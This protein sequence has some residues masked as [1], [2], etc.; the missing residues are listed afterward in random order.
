[1]PTDIELIRDQELLNDHNSSH[2]A[3]DF[4]SYSSY[5]NHPMSDEQAKDLM[6]RIKSAFEYRNGL[7]QN[8]SRWKST[9]QSVD[10]L[11]ISINNINAIFNTTTGDYNI[12]AGDAT[13]EG[14]DPSFTSSDANI[15]KAIDGIAIIN[16]LL[17][18]NEIDDNIDDVANTSCNK[19]VKAISN[20]QT[21]TNH[22]K[23]YLV[24]EIVHVDVYPNANT[25]TDIINAK[26]KFVNVILINTDTNDFNFESDDPTERNNQKEYIISV[27]SDISDIIKYVKAFTTYYVE[28]NADGSDVHQNITSAF[29]YHVLDY[30]IQMIVAENELFAT[31]LSKYEKHIV[32]DRLTHDS[33]PIDEQRIQ[34]NHA[35][36]IGSMCNGSCVGLCYGTC[37]TT[38]NGCSSCTSYCSTYCGASCYGTCGNAVCDSTCSNTCKG[39][40]KDYCQQTC[41]VS[42]G[43][44]CDTS[45]IES[46]LS[47]CKGTC[48]T[49]CINTCDNK[50]VNEC[51]DGC[52]T[53]CTTNCGKSCLSESSS[54]NVISNPKDT[55][56]ITVE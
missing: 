55:N 10:I 49:S 27:L 42:C 19:I 44:D 43:D 41:T 17:R 50:C 39:E 1:M 6:R 54:K 20:G 3:N 12:E 38:C 23:Q 11:D 15:I 8:G 35:P 25:D 2:A 5:R 18:I 29:D 24:N 48:D 26:N 4:D 14:E 32:P 45:C 52:K 22:M 31:L 36:F 7:L 9:A 47:E 16:S 51:L 13:V 30:I 34:Y 46:C 28:A 33:V 37:I 53:D 56:V 21:F 40:C